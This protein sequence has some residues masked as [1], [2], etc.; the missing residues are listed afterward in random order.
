METKPVLYAED[1]EDDV[2]FMQRAFQLAEIANPLVIAADGQQALDYIFGTGPY[3]NRAEHPA[4]GLV[5]LDLNM[6]KHSGIEVLD[7]IR[8]TPATASLPVVVVTSSMQSSDIQRAYRHGVNGY[9]VKPT[10]PDELLPIVKS[11][12]DFWLTH[13]CVVHGFVKVPP[14]EHADLTNTR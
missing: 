9:V 4:P 14:E 2:F 12:K 10:R 6:P 1:E 8:K 7:R 3:S 13:N 5:L 11:I